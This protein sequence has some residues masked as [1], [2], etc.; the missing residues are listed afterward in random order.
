MTH[1]PTPTQ[2]RERSLRG[3]GERLR[4]E[5]VDAATALLAETG[6]LGA[7]TLRATA[8]R[9][10]IAATSIYLHFADLDSLT[11][12]AISRA[13]DRFD[14]AREAAAQRE[15]EP[16]AILRARARAYCRFAL[17]NPGLYRVL[18]DAERPVTERSRAAFQTLV[19][20]IARC[21]DAG[22]ALEDDAEH[23]AQLLW[24]ALHGLASLRINRPQFP[25]RA[26]LDEDVDRV[27]AAI[28]GLR[29]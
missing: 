12:A 15:S 18:F 28:V 26:P 23:L 10:G 21:Q 24:A 22:H 3:D 16:G 2:R 8:R 1:T 20:A 14:A 19:R 7:L 27:V 13:F 4:E 6:D 11:E 17:D 9:V 5:L 25:W 29:S